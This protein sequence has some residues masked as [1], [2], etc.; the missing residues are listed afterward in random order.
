MRRRTSSPPGSR[1]RSSVGALLD[2][3]IDAEDLCGISSYES[4]VLQRYR[5]RARRFLQS[6]A[7]CSELRGERFAAGAAGIAGLFAMEV[8]VKG[9]AREWLW[10]IAGE[11]PSAYVPISEAP[12][13]RAAMTSYCAMIER[14]IADRERGPVGLEPTAASR[15]HLQKQ[16][17]VLR[18]YVI[19]ALCSPEPDAPPEG[20]VIAVERCSPPDPD[21][22]V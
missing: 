16:L 1:G 22:D 12:S 7:W 19:P 20:L 13:T 11:L 15:E 9:A 8:L 4:S 17:S 14:W 10:V 2:S 18:G 6:F 5:Q 3:L 21:S